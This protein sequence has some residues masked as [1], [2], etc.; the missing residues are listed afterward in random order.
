LAS[1]VIP[2]LPSHDPPYGEVCPVKAGR[3]VAAF[4]C[5]VPFTG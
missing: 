1:S 2:M 3:G 4:P 5:S